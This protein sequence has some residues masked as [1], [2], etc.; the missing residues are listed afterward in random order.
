MT[1][2]PKGFDAFRDYCDELQASGL[3]R[4]A[5]RWGI[6]K[7]ALRRGAGRPVEELRDT[8]TDTELKRYVLPDGAVLWDVSLRSPDGVDG[9]S[10]YTADFIFSSAEVAAQGRAIESWLDENPDA[11]DMFIP[12]R[13]SSAPDRAREALAWLEQNLARCMSSPLAPMYDDLRAE[14]M[15]AV[16]GSEPPRSNKW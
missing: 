11:Y 10:Y 16:E 5:F 7:A 1:E 13:W 6:T 15:R 3:H 4:E 9:T 12:I 8:E 14:L 2:Q